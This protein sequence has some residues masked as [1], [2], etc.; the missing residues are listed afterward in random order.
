MPLKVEANNGLLLYEGSTREVPRGRRSRQSILR[1]DMG[2]MVHSC[3]QSVQSS[4][5]RH[6]RQE[7][8]NPNVAACY[9]PWEPPKPAGL[10]LRRPSIALPQPIGT[11]M[12]GVCAKTRMFRPRKGLEAPGCPT[13]DAS[14][15]LPGSL[16]E[17]GGGKYNRIIVLP[18]TVDVV[19]K[20]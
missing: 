16:D 8:N 7:V 2:F 19:Y 5:P 15:N 10:V 11:R 4:P 20:H 17:K 14:R 12:T 1:S 13:A 18:W 3:L 9:P 6:M